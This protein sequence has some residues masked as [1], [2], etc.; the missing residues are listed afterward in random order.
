MT[1]TAYD[2]AVRASAPTRAVLAW[3]ELTHPTLPT[4]SAS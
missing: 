2:V 3:L 1:S 4:S